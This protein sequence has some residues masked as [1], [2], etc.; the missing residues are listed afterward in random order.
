M[1]SIENKIF[2]LQLE[3]ESY[4]GCLPNTIFLG[5]EQIKELTLASKYII[6]KIKTSDSPDGS[7]I[8]TQFTG[9]D[10]VRVAGND[11]LRVGLVV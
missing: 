5:N 7:G 6:N 9:L 8:V 4:T 11:Y 2:R 3:F 10:I 1:S